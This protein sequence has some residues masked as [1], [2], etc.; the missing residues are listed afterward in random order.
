MV[1]LA[2]PSLEQSLL[3]R[4][5]D[6]ALKRLLKLVIISCCFFFGP[7]SSPSRLYSGVCIFSR[8]YA[9][10]LLFQEEVPLHVSDGNAVFPADGTFH[11]PCVLFSQCLV[12]PL[13]GNPMSVLEVRSSSPTLPIS[14]FC[15]SML[16]P[17]CGASFC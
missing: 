15:W 5:E 16:H 9:V 10:L 6:V 12:V 14:S 13:L 7:P 8:H 3:E 1:L 4:K 17:W 11:S 2:D